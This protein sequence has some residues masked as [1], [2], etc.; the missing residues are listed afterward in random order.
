MTNTVKIKAIAV[1]QIQFGLSVD[2]N[3]DDAI[4]GG[5][6]TVKRLKT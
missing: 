6:A 3:I 1:S 4:I 2:G 5:R